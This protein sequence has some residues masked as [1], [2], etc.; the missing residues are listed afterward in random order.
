MLSEALFFVLASNLE[1]LDGAEAL[2]SRGLPSKY[3]GKGS[4]GNVPIHTQ[5]HWLEVYMML[6]D[7]V[8]S[9]N[10]TLIDAA[11]ALIETPPVALR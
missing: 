4:W 6:V 11:L 7:A 9:E 8:E 3:T 5:E 10:N 2:H 1:Q